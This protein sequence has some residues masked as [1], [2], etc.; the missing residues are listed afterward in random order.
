MD[1]LITERLFWVFLLLT[2]SMCYTIMYVEWGG[3]V[4]IYCSG[5]KSRQKA[6]KWPN[7]DYWYKWVH[8][9]MI[10]RF[11]IFTIKNLPQMWTVTS[12]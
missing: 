5:V 2:G 11:S 4:R 6:L 10:L 3:I 9:R 1:S 8:K 12:G 7:G